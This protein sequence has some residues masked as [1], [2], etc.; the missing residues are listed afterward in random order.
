M[1]LPTLHLALE[2]DPAEVFGGLE[3]VLA[4]ARR[5]GLTLENLTFD[6]DA[7][8]AVRLSATAP[9]PELLHVFVRRIG[10][11]VDVR[12]VDAEFGD[13]LDALDGMVSVQLPRAEAMAA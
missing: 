8:H 6:A 13:D 11:G 1:S 9:M 10:H 4:N 2:L 3:W 5:T 12:I 7:R